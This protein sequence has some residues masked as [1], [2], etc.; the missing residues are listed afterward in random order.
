VQRFP[1]AISAENFPSGN[2]KS[3]VLGSVLVDA[4]VGGGG[5]SRR[6]KDLCGRRYTGGMPK[7]DE[8]HALI[9]ALP[10]EE[11]GDAHVVVGN[12][13]NGAGEHQDS[14]APSGNLGRDFLI[15]VAQGTSGLDLDQLRTVR[16]RAWR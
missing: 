1:S 14:D 3:N 5:P 10:E 8:L 13:E 9:D 15:S 11:L 12:S 4:G 7:R 16:E 6:L 2:V